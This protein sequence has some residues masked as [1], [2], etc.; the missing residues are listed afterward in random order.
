[1]SQ[2]LAIH[3]CS[4]SPFD[5]NV[6]CLVGR[7]SIKYYRL[8]DTEIRQLSEVTMKDHN[9]ISHCW[10]RQP[11]DHVI[12]GT[13][14]GKIVLFR[15]GDKSF[16][17]NCCP[18]LDSPIASL[19]AV[20]GGFV[21]GASPGKFLFF[22]LD[23]TEHTRR[24]VLRNEQFRL[25]HTVSSELS[26]R[27]A[28][29][30]ALN[31][32]E[33][34][35]CA[36][37]ADG[38]LLSIPLP[39]LSSASMQSLSL[40][41]N[42]DSIRYPVSSF[43]GPR[44]IVGMDVCTR[45]SLFVTVGRDNT[46]RLWNIQNHQ[47]DLIKEF[48]EEIFSV[49]LHPTGLHVAV[50]FLDKVRLYHILLDDLR[51][52][53]ELPVKCCRVCEFSQGGNLFATVN[54]NIISVFDTHSGERAVDLR[55]HNSK[56][57]SLQWLQ[58]GCQLL[59]CGQDGVVYLWDLD[60]PKRTAEFV[61]KRNMYTSVVI[62]QGEKESQMVSTGGTV[63][64]GECVYAV[65]SDK[66]LS[67]LQM[68]DLTAKRHYDAGV[69]MTHLAIS[70]SR[71]VL[72][73]SCGEP[74]KPGYVR[75]Y[76]YPVSGDN[77]ECPCLGSPITAMRLTPDG[78]FLLVGDESGC[79]ALF[80]LKEKQERIQLNAGSVLPDLVSSIAWNDEVL[81][82][83]IELEDRAKYVHCIVL[84]LH[85]KH[86]VLLL[87]TTCFLLSSNIDVSSPFFVFSL[88]PSF[89]IYITLHYFPL[90]YIHYP[91]SPSR[92]FVFLFIISYAHSHA[93]F[94]SLTAL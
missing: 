34:K 61:K 81:V 86:I 11:D 19:V 75:A 47:P 46:L 57:R 14:T 18:V 62:A 4:F 90:F 93:I 5:S 85:S 69:L 71:N 91:L 41:L 24:L 82:T 29:C 68:S 38:Q 64:S 40:S 22:S 66:V 7:D 45:K 27:E 13:D 1:M 54:G 31:V 17:L 53:I 12:A 83:R 3:Q 20:A 56:V 84:L 63:V 92:F 26:K 25:V 74:N 6:V 50:G 89:L 72:L 52:C 51:L 70:T 32:S 44:A 76:A 94:F 8:I 10:L 67:E 48:G 79:I 21:A 30:L 87:D 58:S 16:S 28:V 73:A 39:S 33:D 59:S 78:L 77:D 80:E 55:G 37:T 60:G 36:L 2:N 35:L 49:A 65:G 23:C 9:F 43:H 88:F 42:A 15:S